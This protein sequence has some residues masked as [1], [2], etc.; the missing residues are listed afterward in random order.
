MN[1][2]LIRN[3]FGQFLESKLDEKK[4]I[5]T[6][7]SYI[8]STNDE[9]SINNQNEDIKDIQEIN[10]YEIGIQTIKKFEKIER[11]NSKWKI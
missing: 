2:N 9:T 4:I 6:Q 11:T 1:N 10:N 7:T 8:P 5:V 3:G